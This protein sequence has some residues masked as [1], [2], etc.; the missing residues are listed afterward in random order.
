MQKGGV[1]VTLVVMMIHTAI[2]ARIST[3]DTRQ[4]VTNQLREL[5]R[6]AR[7]QGWKV[8]GEYVDRADGGRG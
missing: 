4:N 2:Y 1:S 6:Y 7:K 8:H 3:D 5:R